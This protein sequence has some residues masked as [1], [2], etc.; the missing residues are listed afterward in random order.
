[1]CQYYNCNKPA[2]W[3]VTHTYKDG[4]VVRLKFCD[5][6]QKRFAKTHVKK[7]TKNAQIPA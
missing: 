5:T 7:R 3:T 1:M 2:R 4:S 6:C